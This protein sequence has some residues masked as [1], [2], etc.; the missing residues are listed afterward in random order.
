MT[1]DAFEDLLDRFGPDPTDWPTSARA[2]AERL[3]AASAAA[4][5]ALA[6]AQRLDALIRARPI[7]VSDAAVGRVLARLPSIT[8]RGRS[9]LRVALGAWGL[10]PLTPR[11]G[12]LAATLALGVIAGAWFGGAPEPSP[13]P[14]RGGR[15]SSVLYP[16]V[17]LQELVR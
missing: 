9:P 5:D 15:L 12:F 16:D 13:A 7:T 11:I 1:P 10:M 14:G 2:P 3:L 8:A 4:R 6:T 17:P